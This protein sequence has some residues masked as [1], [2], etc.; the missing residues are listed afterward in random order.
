MP[1][2]I[3]ADNEPLIRKVDGCANNQENLSKIGEHIPCVHSMSTIWAFDY[4]ENKLLYIVK[5]IV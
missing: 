3:Y 2:I 5:K 1:Y 4:I